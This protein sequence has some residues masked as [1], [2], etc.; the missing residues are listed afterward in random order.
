MALSCDD[1]PPGQK[2]T[3]L[4]EQISD[5][6]K[7]GTDEKRSN[8]HQFKCELEQAM[9]M[10]ASFPEVHL[11]YMCTLQSDILELWKG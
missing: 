3:D 6:S 2:L 11:N 9:D 1:L 5:I 7:S 8:E 10:N 4:K